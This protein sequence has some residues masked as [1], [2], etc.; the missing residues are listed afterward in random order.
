MVNALICPIFIGGRSKDRSPR[1][2]IFL[3]IFD[4]IAPIG[5]MLPYFE[6]TIVFQQNFSPES[7]EVTLMLSFGVLFMIVGTIIMTLSRLILG[8]FGKPTVV[9]SNQHTLI[10]KGTYRY[11]RHPIYS[12]LILL[13]GGYSLAFFSIASTIL[14]L[15]ILGPFIIYRIKAEEKQLLELFGSEYLEYMQRTKRIIP[16]IY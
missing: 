15:I 11:I 2:T 6:Y 16:F 5:I 13:I 12:S 4:L 1:T 8:T 14:F 9:N 3:V 7:F 10:T